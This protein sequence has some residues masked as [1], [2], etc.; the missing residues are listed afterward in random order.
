MNRREAEENCLNVVPVRYQRY[1]DAATVANLNYSANV[2]A[3]IPVPHSIANCHRPGR[4]QRV[5]VRGPDSIPCK[6][7]FSRSGC[8][9]LL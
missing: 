7:N 6:T 5:G 1:V 8:W 3:E 9:R 2:S 4:L